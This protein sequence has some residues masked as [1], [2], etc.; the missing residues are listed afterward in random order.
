VPHTLHAPLFMLRLLII[1]VAALVAGAMNA[2]AGGGTMVV[3]PTLLFLGVPPI[4]ANATCALG[5]WPSGIA[6]AIAYRDFHAAPRRLILALTAVSLLGG[7]WGAWL[8]LHTPP[9]FFGRLVPGLLVF[10]LLVFSFSGRRPRPVMGTPQRLL[11]MVAAVAAQA[12]IAVYGGYFGAGMGV[13]MMAAFAATLAY[14]VHALNGLRSI[15]ATAI[16][17]T[18]IGY[19]IVRHAILWRPG[20]VM[21]AGSALGTWGCALLVRRLDPRPARRVVLTV[22]WVMI[23]AYIAHAALGRH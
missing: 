23:L 17:A 12:G 9:V 11:P 22:A 3:F 19:F 10:A 18:A 4:A 21:V 5:V 16:N 6:G 8:L 2:V 14:Q 1:F 20:L 15:C 7:A 13:L